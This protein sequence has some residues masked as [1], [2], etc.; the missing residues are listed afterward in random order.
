MIVN[1][2]TTFI[3]GLVMFLLLPLGNNM[4]DRVRPVKERVFCLVATVIL[5]LVLIG[6]VI[7]KLHI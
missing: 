7:F 3:I 4:V 5:V 2:V 6:L 1:I